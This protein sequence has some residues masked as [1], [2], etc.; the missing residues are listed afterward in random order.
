MNYLFIIVILFL[1]I[2]IFKQHTKIS[3]LEEK[4]TKDKKEFY[5]NPNNTI[6]SIAHQW[7]QPLMELSSIFVNIE[8]QIDMN[9]VI[10][11]AKLT[12]AIDKSNNILRYMSHTIDDFNNFLNSKKD[13]K[14]CNISE[15][16]DMSIDI[17]ENTLDDNGIE[18]I[19]HK[20]DDI[21]VYVVENEYIQVLI[22][23]ISN[24]KDILIE[25]QIKNPQITIT[26]DKV[27]VD[28]DEIA[29]QAIVYISDNGGGIQAQQIDDIFKP[30]YSK[31]NFINS[32]GMG[33]FMS[34][35]II[36]NHFDGEIRANNNNSGAVF[37]IS[38]PH[39]E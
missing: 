22:N 36:E 29:N 27:L 31:R 39:Y 2:V 35:V 18:L 33:L 20:Y 21:K 5:N 13:Y 37:T 14:I 15:L 34:K 17:V 3:A 25:R 6:G 30:Y 26:I 10:S 7:R 11:T 32:T 4:I 16:I 38:L 8:S 12:Q 23:I 9:R 24:A 28:T 1:I 19:I